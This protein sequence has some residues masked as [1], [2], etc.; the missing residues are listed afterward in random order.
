M[1]GSAGPRVRLHFFSARNVHDVSQIP[2]MSPTRKLPH[3][4]LL[5]HGII[6]SSLS[7]HPPDLAPISR[8]QTHF[9]EQRFAIIKDFLK[10]ILHILKK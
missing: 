8:K 5:G 9:D 10:N 4:S 1:R 6:F 2:S 3:M 7:P